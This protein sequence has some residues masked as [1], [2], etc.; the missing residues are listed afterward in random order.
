MDNTEI[1]FCKEEGC[2][3]ILVLEL[4]RDEKGVFVECKKA[5]HKNYLTPF[6]LSELSKMLGSIANEIKEEA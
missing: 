3:S 4:K 6:E 5:Q 2:G 1:L